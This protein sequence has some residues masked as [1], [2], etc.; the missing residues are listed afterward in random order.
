MRSVSSVICALAGATMLLAGT[1]FAS[2]EGKVTMAAWGGGGALIVKRAY[3]APFTEATGIEFELVEVPDP[4]AA[5]A[6]AQGQPPYNVAVA[7]SF[8]AVAMANRGLVHE[9]TEEDIPAIK[10]IPKEYWVTNSDGKII[11]MPVYFLYLGIAYNTDLAKASDFASWHDLLDPKWKDKV[12][13]TRAVFAA[14]YDLTIFAKINGGD[15]RNIEPGIPMLRDLAKNTLNIYTSMANFQ[16]QLSRGEVV[17]A[18]FYSSQIMIM[19]RQGVQ[20]VDM[21]IPKEGGLALSYLYVIPK[22]AKDI[23]S[24]KKFLNSIANVQ[25]QLLAA[26]DGYLPL[27]PAAELSPELAA[28]YGFTLAELMESTYAPDW[29][30]IGSA[31]EERV[32]L[33]EEIIDSAH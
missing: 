5:V 30:L 2:A 23:E 6:A 10:S 21:V 19:K 22:G 24:A 4:S 25:S 3:A 17:A 9:L 18:P 28:E 33:V 31:I 7:A 12:S 20:N 29:N 14:P 15:E 8:Q 16:T 32:S 26:E 11:G 27:N 13:M 1:G